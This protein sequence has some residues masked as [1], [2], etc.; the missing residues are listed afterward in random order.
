MSVRISLLYRFHII[1]HHLSSPFHATHF[2]PY[3]IYH[4]YYWCVYVIILYFNYILQSSLLACFAPLLHGA[5]SAVYL[6]VCVW[7]GFKIELLTAT[8]IRVMYNCIIKVCCSK[9][10]RAMSCRVTHTEYILIE[11]IHMCTTLRECVCVLLLFV[12]LV[13]RVN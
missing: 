10:R 11:S 7:C 2:E 9:C 3:I 4:Y 5:A 8:Y 1:H 6:N 13:R 12:L